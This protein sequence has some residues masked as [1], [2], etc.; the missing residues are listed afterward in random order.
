MP[1]LPSPCLDVCKYKLRGG[2]CIACA[3]TEMQK[4]RF[5]ILDDAGRRAFIA[6]LLEQQAQ[7]GSA[8]TWPQEYTLK[9]ERSGVTPPSDLLSAAPPRVSAGAGRSR[10]ARRRSLS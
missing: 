10:S 6:E 8:V 1:D 5:E 4:A 7:A 9:C 2:R 3:M